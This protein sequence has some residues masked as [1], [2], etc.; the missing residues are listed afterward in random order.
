MFQSLK[1]RNPRKTNFVNKEQI[2]TFHIS[3]GATTAPIKSNEAEILGRCKIC[4]FPCNRER[5][6]RLH[7]NSYAGLGINYAATA[8][9]GTCVGDKR[10]PAA[11][12]VA[13]SADTYN[14]R[15]VVGGCPSCGSYLWDGWK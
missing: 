13:T 7:P 11:G 2:G 1:H 9:A 14:E 10:V 15:D 5:D 12:A 8:T 3:P 4:G 6:T